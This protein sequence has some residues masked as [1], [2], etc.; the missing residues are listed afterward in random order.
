MGIPEEILASARERMTDTR[1]RYQAAL[2]ELNGKSAEME[3][4]IAGLAR[5]EEKARQ[6]ADEL[7]ARLAEAEKNRDDFEREKRKLLKTEVAKAREEISMLAQKAREGDL[8][9][10]EET[11]RKLKEM[12]R[13][14]IV[15]I[16]RPDSVPLDTL[17]DG[18]FVWITALDRK[19]KLLR[20]S[21]GKAEVLCGE[22]RMTLDTKD[23]IGVKQKEREAE[24][25]KKPLVM[26]SGDEAPSEIS[27][28]GMT[29][30]DAVQA[31][32]K[33]LDTQYLLGADRV[34]V[35]HGR[36][37]LRTK[38]AEYLKGSAYVQTFAQGA[39]AEGGDAVSIVELKGS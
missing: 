7:S 20:L 33:F 8:K 13:K 37:V 22:A 17:K 30:E 27:L 4:K 2:A 25:N 1:D 34:K 32:D 23:I 38:V 24:K 14:L 12:E 36:G 35:I 11:A 5:Q 9:A 18:D 15:E 21:G 3:G 16:H 10:K 39:S 26:G 28:M 19:A 31:L 6:T 29:G